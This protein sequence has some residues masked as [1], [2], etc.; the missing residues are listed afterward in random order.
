MIVTQLVD[1]V[2]DG[3]EPAALG[4]GLL[5]HIAATRSGEHLEASAQEMIEPDR[6]VGAGDLVAQIHAAAESP[7][8]LELAHGAVLEADQRDSIVLGGDRMHQRIGPTHHLDRAIVLAH[9]AADDLGAMAAQV[10]DRPTACQFGIPEPGAVRAGVGFTR[11]HPQHI[12]ERPGF[13]RAERLEGLGGIDQIFEI[14]R[15]DPG[16][17]DGIE[18]LFSFGGSAPQRLGA[19]HRLA[20]CRGHRDGLDMLGVWQADHHRVG[21]RVVD[22]LLQVARGLGDTPLAGELLRPF[23]GARIHHRHLIAAALPVQRHSIEHTDQSCPEHRDLMRPHSTPLLRSDTARRT[24]GFLS[25]Q[26]VL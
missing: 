10:D 22:R 25:A 4:L 20:R 16:P 7:A 15:E 6:A 13:D 1:L 3:E 5:G 17:L 12:A 23:R 14:A 8:N 26:R 9:K 2:A 11:A 19:Q 21:L 18:H 24:Q